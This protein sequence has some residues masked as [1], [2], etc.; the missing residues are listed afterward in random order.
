[1][2]TIKQRLLDTGQ[3][4]NN[5]A[6]D[7][8]VNL[9]Q[10]N[11]TQERIT[12]QT[13]KHHILPESLFASRGLAE[14]NSKNCLVNLFFADHIL[15][16]YYLWLAAKADSEQR[17]FNAAAVQLLT[18]RVLPETKQ[19]LIDSLPE[20]QV[21]RENYIQL[22]QEHMTGREVSV[23]TKQKISKRRRGVPLSEEHKAALRKPKSN[24]INMKKPKSH[25][26]KLNMSLAHIGKTTRPQTE[27]TKL[28]I[29]ATL[30][31]HAVS[32]YVK[33]KSREANLGKKCL[34]KD[35]D[36]KWFY[37][38]A[39]ITEALRNGWLPKGMPHEESTKDKIKQLHTGRIWV[40]NGE[41][42][43]QIFPEDLARY[44]AIGY[45]KGRKK[46]IK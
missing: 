23:D 22:V 24:T 30:R 15:A 38:E 20:Y 25:Q 43:K 3:F 10:R 14:N 9:I 27:E 42:T 21:L 1:M 19:Q 6:L 33:E 36:Y 34:Y 45:E 26:A 28:K 16:H 31:G 35:G 46:K 7:S 12:G 40:T 37:S 2:Q 13:D 4:I 17:Y 18:R 44:K 11:A 39:S 8:Y 29:S 32:D 5:D 41:E